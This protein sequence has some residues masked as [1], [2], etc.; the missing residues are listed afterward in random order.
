MEIVIYRNP[1]PSNFFAKF[2]TLIYFDE[3]R[4]HC[5]RFLDKTMKLISFLAFLLF[6]LRFNR[7]D[8]R[9]NF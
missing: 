7:D 4:K 3:G 5:K 9:E 6:L 8:R 1:T 2:K